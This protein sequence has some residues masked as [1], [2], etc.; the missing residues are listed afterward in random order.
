M[1]GGRTSWRG[2]LDREHGEP[3]MLL[4][5]CLH[6]AE[7]QLGTGLH[8]ALT[9][10]LRPAPSTL[11]FTLNDI[12]QGR[13]QLLSSFGRWGNG[14]SER[15]RNLPKVTQQVSDKAGFKHSLAPCTNA[16]GYLGQQSSNK[17]TRTPGC[18]WRLSK[19]YVSIG[20]F[21][22]ICSQPLPALCLKTVC[23]RDLLPIIL[24]PKALLPQKGRKFL[25]QY[26]AP[27]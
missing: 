23:D 14:G 24:L 7:K 11:S 8:Q 13:A 25:L 5:L 26:F 27:R 3:A 19:S 18:T 6:E 10:V 20:D 1:E 17:D 4:D 15:L 9:Q 12:P 16:F 21:K 22:G 2:S